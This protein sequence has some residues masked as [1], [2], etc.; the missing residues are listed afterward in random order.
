MGLSVHSLCE[1]NIFGVSAVSGMSEGHIF[2]QCVLALSPGW[3]VWLWLVV[4]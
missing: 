2:P 4:Q 3:K 1:S